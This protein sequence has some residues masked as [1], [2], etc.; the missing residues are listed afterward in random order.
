MSRDIMIDLETLGTS[1][2][3]IILS[4]GAVRF[5][6]EAGTVTDP[7]GAGGFYTE[8][9]ITDQ[10][11]YERRISA[12]TLQWWMGQSKEAQSVFEPDAPK[13]TLYSALS[14][15][16]RW[17]A[18][19]KHATYVWSNGADFDLPMLVHAY[20]A[21][22]L[23]LPWEPYAGRCYRTYKSLPG[24]RAVAV[25]RLGLHHNALDDAVF[26]AQHVCAI[27]AALFGRVCKINLDGHSAKGGAA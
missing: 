12:S 20:T 14:N 4:I 9:D 13:Q 23:V 6:L 5:D 11:D 25:P 18:P 15:L 10:Q 7:E 16:C 2:D 27:H 26:Q 8:L 21:L 22:N 17:I 1:A 3:A 19:D 24:A